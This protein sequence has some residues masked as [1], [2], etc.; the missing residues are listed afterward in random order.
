AI[1]VRVFRG[2]GVTGVAGSVS[3]CEAIKYQV[4]LSKSSAGACAFQHGT[5]TLTLPN[6]TVETIS[7][8]VPCI[9][10]T[11][12]PCI[13]GV[14]D[15]TSGLF[16]YTVAI[17]DIKGGFTPATADYTGGFAHDTDADSPGVAATTPKN[18]PVVLCT[19]N[20]LCTNDFC[21]ST[22]AGSAACS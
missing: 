12:S 21:D 16:D 11:T 18:T 8:D 22:K 6:G 5:F 15:L 7:N 4:V 17:A 3:Q 14:N 9:G 10:G 13:S 20:N 1:E 19:D 2:D